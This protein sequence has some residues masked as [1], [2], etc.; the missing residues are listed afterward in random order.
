M[1]WNDVELQVPAGFAAFPAELTSPPPEV[2]V[3]LNHPHLLQ[4]TDMPRGG[5]FA[6]LE[7]PALLADEVF[8]FVLKAQRWWKQQ[9]NSQLGKK[10]QSQEKVKST[11]QSQKK[12]ATKQQKQQENQKIKM[13][14][15]KSPQI[16]D[17]KQ[18]QKQNKTRH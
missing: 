3:K 9:N 13:E 14:K 11:K 15:Q 8:A 6:A 2:F 10:I 4:Y 7:E 12:L 17:L 18:A 5:H 1:R 16:E